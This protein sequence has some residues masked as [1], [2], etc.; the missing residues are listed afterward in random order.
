MVNHVTGCRSFD[1]GGVANVNAN[2][3]VAITAEVEPNDLDNIYEPFLNYLKEDVMQ[4]WCKV[5]LMHHYSLQ[6]VSVISDIFYPVV[7]YFI[8]STIGFHLVD[9][10]NA[11]FNYERDVMVVCT[12]YL[13][14]YEE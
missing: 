6:L 9:E 4:G 7:D 5:R 12:V 8:T 10:N 2:G 11:W 13:S 3:V 14:K 1:V